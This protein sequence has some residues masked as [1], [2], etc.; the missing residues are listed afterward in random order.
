MT[1]GCLIFAFNNGMFDYVKLA[2]NCSINISKHLN[3]PTTIVT[4]T[5][6]NFNHN[7][8][9]IITVKTPDSNN[10]F[11][12]DTQ[13]AEKWINF[14][15]SD[16]L[17]VTPYDETILLDADY[18]VNSNQINLLFESN[19][20]VLYHGHSYDI[21]GNTSFEVTNKF[22]VLGFP[23]AW[24]T[25]IYFKK[26]RYSSIFFKIMQMIQANYEHYANIYNFSSSP[27]RNDYALSIA[28]NISNG[29]F[30]S[31]INHIPWELAAVMPSDK[32]IKTDEN[33]Y[34]VK[35]LTTNNGRQLYNKI[36]INDMDLHVMGK[37]DL[38]K[39][40]ENRG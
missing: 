30:L 35:Y 24:A 19:R 9:N 12:H 23:M 14:N 11:F 39:I 36:H 22:G 28:D 26:D 4:N 5:E 8:D 10:R 7:F 20:S 1:K 3:L 40:Y 21:T 15:R 31:K 6:I 34:V 18:V 33:S 2:N 27:Y 17:D 16:A 32:I 38:E 37:K 25:V 13:K 29:H